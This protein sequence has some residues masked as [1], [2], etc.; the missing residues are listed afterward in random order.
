[1]RTGVDPA[2]GWR[3]PA[4]GVRALWVLLWTLSACTSGPFAPGCN[5]RQ[6]G[7]LIDTSGTV[8]A[9]ATVSFE[10]TSPIS[11]NLLFTVL[12]SDAAVD[13]RLQVTTLSCGAQVGCAV[14]DTLTARRTAQPARE[15]QLDGSL[16]KRYKIDVLGDVIQ[17]Q[18]FTIR[19]TFDTGICT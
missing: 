4:F 3:G 9:G 8:V 5:D 13:L 16:G 10:V 2:T 15:M 7:T 11:S 19:V 17:E 18:A 12:W 14:G 1:M 6:T